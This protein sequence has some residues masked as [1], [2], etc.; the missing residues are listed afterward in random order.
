MLAPESSCVMERSLLGEMSR[1]RVR[2]TLSMT[3]IQTN[4]EW[5]YSCF[6]A[7]RCAGRDA[8]LVD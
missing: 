1:K 4:E 7:V 8:V 2:E 5:I 6:A 3:G